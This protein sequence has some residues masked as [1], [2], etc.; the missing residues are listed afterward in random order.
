MPRRSM[1]SFFDG[2]PRDGQSFALSVI[3]RAW[4]SNDVF[5]IRLPTGVGKQ[6]L[7]LCVADWAAAKAGGGGLRTS[8]AVPNNALLKQVTD[9]RPA[10]PKLLGK[11]RYWCDRDNRACG[12]TIVASGGACRPDFVTGPAALYHPDACAMVK[13]LR[14]SRSKT[15]RRLACVYHTL[16]GHKL[17]ADKDVL[18]YD[19]AHNLVKLRQEFAGYGLD[20]VRARVPDRV[21]TVAEL[22][23]WAVSRD[24]RQSPLA[25][26]VERLV[27]D[28]G[29]DRPTHLISIDEDT[30]GPRVRRTARAVPVDV[31]AAPPSM[32]PRRDQKVI[33]MS[34]T[35]GETD[36]QQMGLAG[37]RVMYIDV[38]SDIPPDGRPIYY[39][40]VVRMTAGNEATAVAE[41]ADWL[42]WALDAHWRGVRGVIHLPY[43]IG[44]KL[45]AAMRGNDRL[46]WFSP[47]QRHTALEDF[48]SMR[49]SD[50]VI[51]AAG[52]SEGLDLKDDLA[53]FQ[54]I[55]DT[56]FASMGDPGVRW[57]HENDPVRAEWETV[58]TLAQTFG[59]NSRHPTD[60]GETVV[61]DA[62][63]RG[64]MD[65]KLMPAWA[66]EAYK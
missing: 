45:Y 63:A 66:V 42:G 33:L 1:A 11:G 52:C 47:A 61:V 35:L 49:R 32:W 16:L 2:N 54:V 19:E 4:D 59:R 18:I 23:E 48:I 46:S 15:E 62:C 30:D 22:L 17:A 28:C 14:R 60:F 53:R 55:G 64:P 12:D 40:P 24:G 6:R 8:Y 7:G 43:R 3:E 38:P 41:L 50:H 26:T 5:A 21:W 27:R 57:L 56:P 65:S 37:R 51:I 20:M 31:S 44:E 39:D 34:A 10:Y 13:D 36:I 29:G 25:E 58:K 9:E